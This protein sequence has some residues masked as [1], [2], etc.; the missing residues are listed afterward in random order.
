MI[1]D[2]A[3]TLAAFKGRGR[4]HVHLQHIRRTVSLDRCPCTVQ[5]PSVNEDQYQQTAEMEKIYVSAMLANCAA[6][7]TK[8]TAGMLGR[9]QRKGRQPT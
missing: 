7:S 4:W 3:K 2:P 8:A 1:L 9:K 6:S 5:V